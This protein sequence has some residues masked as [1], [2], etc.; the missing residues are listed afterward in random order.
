[1]K[2]I[3]FVFTTSIL[4]CMSCLSLA[5]QID[6]FEGKPSPTLKAALTNLAEYNT[7]LA[8]LIEQGALSSEDLH[9]VHE[10]TYT[11]ENAIERLGKEQL[12]LSEVLEE[13]H[14]ASESADEKTVKSNA[15]EYLERSA[16]LTYR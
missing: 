5:E 14:L 11:L 12:R 9:K 7:K 15:R 16:P 6:H 1:M 13:V 10:L 3:Q 2:L 8:S 4:L